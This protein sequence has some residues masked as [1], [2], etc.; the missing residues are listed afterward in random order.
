VLVIKGPL[1]VDLNKIQIYYRQIL[2]F[3]LIE[4]F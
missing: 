2:R 3:E 1:T 4:C